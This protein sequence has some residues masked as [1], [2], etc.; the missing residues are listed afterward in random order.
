LKFPI[1]LICTKG[2]ANFDLSDREFSAVRKYLEAGNHLFICGP[3]IAAVLNNDVGTPEAKTFL[4]DY[5]HARYIAGESRNSSIIGAAEDPIGDDLSFNIWVPGLPIDFQMTNVIAPT[6]GSDAIFTYSDGRTA[7][8]KYAG[9]HKV[10]YM[11]FG[12]EAVDSD[13]NTLI[14]DPSAIRSQLLIRIINWL[15]FIEH[16]PLQDTADVD[17]TRSVTASLAGTVTVIE[18][19]TLFWRLQGDHDYTAVDMVENDSGGYTAEI[20]PPGKAAVVEYYLQT[21]HTYYDWHSPICAPD[22]VY[23]Y[24]AGDVPSCAKNR[25]PFPAAFRMSQNYPN[26]FNPITAIEYE[27]PKPG[28]VRLT[29]CDV[30]GRRIRTLIDT[31]KP[32]GRFQMI[33]DGTNE[34]GLPVAAGLY[35][36]CME[37]GEYIKVIK[38]AL[39]K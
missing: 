31:H 22:S 17:S 10:V 9:D 29:I 1:V 4:Q 35:F 6:A 13:Q 38:L 19:M 23:R 12:L 16:D 20:P 21:K 11:A 18:A 15:N 28:S 3:W 14:G 8:I 26:P 30:L 36:C 24:I 2:L 7:A 33:W 25:E 27:L 5:L 37:S 39:L 32:A 34:Q